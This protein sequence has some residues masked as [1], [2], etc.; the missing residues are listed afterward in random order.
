MIKELAMK[1]EKLAKDIKKMSV[2]REI[3]RLMLFSGFKDEES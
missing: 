3:N 1:D 2:A